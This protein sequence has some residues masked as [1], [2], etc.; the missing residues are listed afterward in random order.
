VTRSRG[1]RAAAVGVGYALAAY[2]IWGF[3]PA[4]W[5]ALGSISTPELLAHRMLWGFGVGLVLLAVT[6][7]FR[8]FVDALRSTRHVLPI[9]LSALLITANWLTFIWAVNTGRVLDTSLGYYINPLISVVLGAIFLGERF[10]P[11]Q[12]TAVGIAAL[13]VLQLTVALGSLPWISLVLAVSF[14]LYGLV[15]KLAPVA[16]VTG[17]ALETFL[18]APA[19]AAY[20][21]FLGAENRL[22]FPVS[23]AFTNALVAGSGVIT[24][25]PLL[26]FNGATKRLRLS[27]VGIFQYISPSVAFA[28]AVLAYGEPFTRTH[29]ITFGC[30]WF[31]LGVYSVDSARALRES[32]AG[33]SL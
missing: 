5:R 13:G 29:A 12:L 16:P 26:F 19:A 22:A 33:A 4:Y 23:D 21:I 8:T 32:G 1:D 2:G 31:A 17:F 6:A 3:A 30:V 11:L 25:A 7:G 9:A 27:T 18:M 14:A 10:R 24:A 20:L 28:L 15:R